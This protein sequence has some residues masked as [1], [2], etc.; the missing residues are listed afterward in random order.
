MKQVACFTIYTINYY[1]IKLNYTLNDAHGF[2]GTV[3]KR[4]TETK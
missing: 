4:W 1:T 2:H 3:R